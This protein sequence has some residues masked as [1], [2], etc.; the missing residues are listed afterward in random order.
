M[1]KRLSDTAALTAQGIK[2]ASNQYAVDR[3]PYCGEAYPEPA[4]QSADYAVDENKR[5]LAREIAMN[6]PVTYCEPR[7]EVRRNTGAGSPSLSAAI[8]VCKE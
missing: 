3:S 5:A 6:S 4:Y 7:A 1:T 2:E 8:K